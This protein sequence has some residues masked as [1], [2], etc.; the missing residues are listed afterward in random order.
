MRRRNQMHLITH[1]D[2]AG[3]W[4]HQM[5]IHGL[6]RQRDRNIHIAGQKAPA[7]FK[8]R[9]RRI[10]AVEHMRLDNT[11]IAFHSHRI[12]QLIAAVVHGFDGQ[13]LIPQRNQHREHILGGYFFRQIQHV[14]AE[15]NVLRGIISIIQ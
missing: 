7:V 4:V 10:H 11:P 9:F 12:H 5:H 8:Q 1:I 14:F 15:F 2:R 13:V 3:I 6:H